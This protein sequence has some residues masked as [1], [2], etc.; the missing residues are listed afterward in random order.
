VTIRAWRGR[1]WRG[2]GAAGCRCDCWTAIGGGD[3]QV[4]YGTDCKHAAFRVACS[5]RVYCLNAFRMD[6]STT[7]LRACA[8]VAFLAAVISWSVDCILQAYNTLNPVIKENR[9]RKFRLWN[10]SNRRS[11]ILGGHLSINVIWNL[12]AGCA[13]ISVSAAGGVARTSTSCVVSSSQQQLQDP[14][15]SPVT[16]GSFSSPSAWPTLSDANGESLRGRVVRTRKPV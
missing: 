6:S 1:L 11:D 4:C 15:S 3:G 16:A 14:T 13:A 9:R 7:T 12:S 2:A 5:E 8:C 10:R